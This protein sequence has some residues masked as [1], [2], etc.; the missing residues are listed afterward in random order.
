MNCEQKW[1]YNLRRLFAV[2]SFVVVRSLDVRFVSGVVATLPL[3]TF[4]NS[5]SM[6]NWSSFGRSRK[7]T[8]SSTL[9]IFLVSGYSQIQ[10]FPWKK[11]LFLQPLWHCNQR[12]TRKS[13]FPMTEWHWRHEDRLDGAMSTST[14]WGYW[15]QVFLA[16]AIFKSLMEANLFSFRW[17]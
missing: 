14:S 6:Y 11:A 1:N 2:E 5:V 16:N 4:A 9:S 13:P 7:P 12:R 10:V 3:L 15:V 8:N 17:R